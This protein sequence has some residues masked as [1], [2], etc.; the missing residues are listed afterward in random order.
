MSEP[1]PPASSG[2]EADPGPLR[3]PGPTQLIL[4]LDGYEGPLDLLLN[5]ARQQKVDLTH[6]SILALAEQFLAFIESAKRV[7]MD[8]AADY[9][10]MA[11]WLAYLKSRLLLPAAPGED[12][13][14]AGEMAAALAH[15]LR[16]LD[17]MREAGAR[18]MARPLLGQ[19]RFV[20]GRP[21]P[22]PVQRTNVYELSLY[23]LLKT[24]AGHEA[25]RQVSRMRVAPS[26]FHSLEEA[27]H[28][29]ARQLGEMPDWS[30]LMRFLPEGLS[31]GIGQRSAVAA[32]FAASLELARLGKLRL[33]QLEP[34]GPIYVRAGEAP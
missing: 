10:V 18:L 16:R 11:A 28:R 20:R 17:G 13:P 31:P 19:E 22:T 14:S 12:E 3:A 24:Y 30:L 2:F 4:N 32:T 26:E 8:V 34:F 1:A 6:I 7:D 21:E 33:R 15:Q 23:D 27:Y 5:L 9:L 25:H 29:L